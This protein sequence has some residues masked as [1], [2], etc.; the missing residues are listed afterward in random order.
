MT[1]RRVAAVAAVALVACGGPRDA[2]EISGTIEIRDI[3][4]APLASGR[5]QRLLK[6]EG[7]TVQAGD[8]IAVLDQPGL[9]AVI[10]QRRAEA[11]AAASRVA[12]VGGAE[13]DSARAA[14]DL[15]RGERLRA[16]SI[17][18]QQQYDA[19]RNAAAAT[20]AQ[21]A[22]ARA[23]PSES[24]AARAAVSAALA[25]REELTVLAPAAGVILTR[26]AEPGE[27]LAAGTPIVSLGL[28]AHPWVRAYVNERVIGRLRM[29]AA[30]QIRVD[31]YPGRVFAG[32]VTDIAPEAEF[33][34]RVA[35][36]ERER[37]DLMFGIKVEPSDGDAGGRL[38]AGMPA[39]IDLTLLP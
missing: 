16:Q 7:D 32:R 9:D 15:A 27:V 39:T 25:T 4:I 2:L 17:V 8:T 6:D 18:S 5:L 19:L 37:A 10:E 26:Y 22:A 29:G 20:T 36:T 38:K 1:R 3:Q 30:A 11:H 31:A 28:V 12:Q 34:P 35:L 33:T 21:L 14:D 23:A 24:A 13:A